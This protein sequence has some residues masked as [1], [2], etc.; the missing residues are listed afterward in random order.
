MLPSNRTPLAVG[1]A[2][3]SAAV[4]FFQAQP[5]AQSGV[6]YGCANPGNGNL[7]I[8]A[9]T[10]ACRPNETRVTLNI[11]G[12]GIGPTGAKGA[13]GSTGSTGL[14]GSPG[15]PGATGA[16]GNTGLTGNVGPQGAMGPTGPG[17]PSGAIRGTI[18]TCS[19]QGVVVFVPGR[20][21]NVF[22]GAD[23]VFQMD[24]V[25][26][27]TYEVHIERNG[28]ALQVVQAVVTD[29]VFD[30]G[31]ITLN[32]PTCS[33]TCGAGQSM[34]GNT[35]IDTSNDSNNCGGCGR[36]CGGGSVC[37]NGSCSAPPQCSTPSDCPGTDS[38]CASRTCI[39]GVC[40]FNF[41]AAGTPA[42]N[43]TAGDC[44][45]LAC[46]GSGNLINQN[47]DSDLPQDDGNQCTQEV[48]NNGMPT[49]PVKPAGT[50]CNQNGGNVCNST[51][52][53]VP[54]GSCTPQT[55]YPD[56]DADGYGS[57]FF[58][59]VQS[60]TA[61]PGYVANGTDCDDSDSSKSPG[62]PEVC[63]GRDNNCNIQVDEGGVCNTVSSC[64]TVGNFC[65]FANAEAQCV[66]GQCAVAACN[67][68]FDNCDAQ[69]ANGCET[70][71]RTS[72]NNCGACGLACSAG[73]VCTNGFCSSADFSAGPPVQISS[74]QQ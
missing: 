60:C 15:S 45:K 32:D 67:A 14:T 44:K 48:C 20:A 9:A 71:I 35:C 46:D 41:A 6:I 19:P 43:Q 17:A 37:S 66:N 26:P 49:Y 57:P 50:A 68:G 52:Q 73:Q 36:V 29:T 64:G 38:V 31:S 59:T 47:D 56:F 61:P 34:C 51:G 70:D 12:G 58:G 2:L 53:C 4:F 24:N 23:G 27:G 10:E 69:P 65:S 11:A 63:D 1:L 42:P 30:F 5:S 21:F 7:R 55:W 72:L 40:G 13:T 3:A 28:N 33:P 39:A 16:T 54:S 62:A 18:V 8:V 74:G 25:P 22:V